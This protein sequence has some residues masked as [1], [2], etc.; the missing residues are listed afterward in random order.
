M[1]QKVD[2]RKEWI[3]EKSPMHKDKHITEKKGIT[4]YKTNRFKRTIQGWCVCV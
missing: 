1:R 4:G 3:K 2:E